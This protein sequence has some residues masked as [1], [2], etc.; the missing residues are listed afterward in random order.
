MNDFVSI[1][2]VG[3]LQKNV[4]K[5]NLRMIRLWLQNYKNAIVISSVRGWLS[6]ICTFIQ[7]NT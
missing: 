2:L 3:V 7:L 4:T 5:L 1:Q 6:S